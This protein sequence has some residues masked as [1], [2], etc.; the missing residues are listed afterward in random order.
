MGHTDRV[1]QNVYQCPPALT[2]VC[3]IG[4]FLQAVD[5]GK[6]PRRIV[7]FD[8]LDEEMEIEDDKSHEPE[9]DVQDG[10]QD[11]AESRVI[12]PV[13]TSEVVE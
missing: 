7:T 11:V 8:Q 5:Q 13:N 4:K 12:G 10:D 2:A 1:S 6:T 9:E 3:K